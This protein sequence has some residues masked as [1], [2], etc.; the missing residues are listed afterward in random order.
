MFGDFLPF[1]G[2]IIFKWYFEW[3]DWF[4]PLHFGLIKSRFHYC[5]GPKLQTSWFL[6]VLRRHQLPKPTLFIFGEARTPKTNEEKYG[7][8]LETYYLWKYETHF[9]EKKLTFER[10]AF[11]ECIFVYNLCIYMFENIFT[12]MRNWKW[13]IFH[14]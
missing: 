9:F 4:F 2:E 7:N 13:Y 14:Y 3:L 12:K 8:I 1:Y 10:H 6:N 11:F 5:R